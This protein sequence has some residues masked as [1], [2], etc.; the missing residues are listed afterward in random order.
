MQIGDHPK[1][2]KS[3]VSDDIQSSPIS[4]TEL[5]SEIY[6]SNPQ[7]EVKYSHIRFRSIEQ[8][9]GLL[10]QTSKLAFP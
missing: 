8:Y 6:F 4:S 3:H 10:S 1:S 5:F 9:S 2:P 7:G